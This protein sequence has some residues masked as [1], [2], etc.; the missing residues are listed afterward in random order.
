MVIFLEVTFKSRLEEDI[1]EQISYTEVS[2]LKLNKKLGCFAQC[3][4]G[5]HLGE[6]ER[7]ILRYVLMKA[8]I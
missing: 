1:S 2:R 8:A 3:V 7:K 5:R 6:T 4:S